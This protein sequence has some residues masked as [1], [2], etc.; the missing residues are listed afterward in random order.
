MKGLM[1]MIPRSQA[2]ENKRLTD[3]LLAQRQEWTDKGYKHYNSK[4]KDIDLELGKLRKAK[5]DMEQKAPKKAVKGP[6][7][8][9]KQTR[10][11]PL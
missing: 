6:G 7:H 4:I 5:Y 11:E 1:D 8:A 9:T 2:T 10:Y 3:R